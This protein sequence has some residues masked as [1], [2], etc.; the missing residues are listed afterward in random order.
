[1]QMELGHAG[2]AAAHV[3]PRTSQGLGRGQQCLL[4]QSALQ[5]YG[6]VMDMLMIRKTDL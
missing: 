1:M 3:C 4:A 6:Q 2:W 5:G